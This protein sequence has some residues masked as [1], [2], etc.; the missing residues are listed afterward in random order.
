MFRNYLKTT[1]R[2]LL[3]SKAFSLIK[4]LG[5]ALGMACSL[6][7]MLWVKDEYR[8]DA[9][10]K[11]GTQLFSVYE[12]QNHDGQLTAGHQSPGVLADEM[13]KVLPEVQFATQYSWNELNTFEANNKIIKESGNY[14]GSDFFQ[15]FTYPILQGN[16]KTALLST[17]DMAVSK[18]MAVDFF[19]SPEAAL[20]KT[21]RFQNRKNFNITAVF[22]NV[23]K[24]SS[25]QFVYIINWQTFL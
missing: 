3:K 4:I 18:K 5:L 15:M 6:L 22:D 19:G 14:A 9:F 21:I 17:L 1:I 10:H 8:V 24:N 16:A 7:I 2:N 25:E 13:K 23:P 12:R 11:N 20:G